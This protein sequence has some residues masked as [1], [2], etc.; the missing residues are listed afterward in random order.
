MASKLTSKLPRRTGAITTGVELG[1]LSLDLTEG[2][3]IAATV[4]SGERA[5]LNQIAMATT[6]KPMAMVAI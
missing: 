1:K 4:G 2:C 3:W 5:L 6:S